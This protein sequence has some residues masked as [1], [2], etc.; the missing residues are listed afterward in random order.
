MNL[1]S[2]DRCQGPVQQVDGELDKNRAFQLHTT[3]Y[4]LRIVYNCHQRGKDRHLG[5]EERKLEVLCSWKLHWILW[6]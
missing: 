6:R 5:P 2:G 3:M 1:R 4:R